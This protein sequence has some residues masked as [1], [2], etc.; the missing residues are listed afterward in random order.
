MKVKV[1]TLCTLAIITAVISG[2][3][4]AYGFIGKPGWQNRGVFACMQHGDLLK[5]GGNCP[6]GFKRIT[7]TFNGRVFQ[8][9]CWDLVSPQCSEYPEPESQHLP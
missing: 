8:D 6:G 4:S 2:N 1:K 3:A 5:Y 9:Y 7:N